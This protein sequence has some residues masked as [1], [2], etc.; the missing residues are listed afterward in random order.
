[1]Q[2]PE[3]IKNEVAALVKRLPMKL[4]KNAREEVLL[5]AID[6]RVLAISA[7]G[8]LIWLN[9]NKTLLAYF[10]GRMWCGDSSQ[11]SKRTGRYVWKCGNRRFPEKDLDDLFEVKGLRGLRRQRKWCPLSEGFEIIDNLFVGR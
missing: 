11:Y 9:E 10:S 5:E 4:R 6:A 2:R 3:E 1:M 7:E 8:K